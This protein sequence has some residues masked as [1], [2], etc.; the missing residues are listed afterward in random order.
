M[1]SED[2]EYEYE[3]DVELDEE[4]LE[5]EDEVVPSR[6][7]RKRLQTARIN[8]AA[9]TMLSGALELLTPAAP[10]ADPQPAGPRTR[11]STEALLLF[12]TDPN[13]PPPDVRPCNTP[14][15]SKSLQD[16]TSEKIYHLFGNRYFRNYEH[17]GQAS[18]DAKL[19]QGG[20]PCPTIGEFAKIRKCN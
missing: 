3:D 8:P 6:P 15:G 19:V 17:Y 9:L 7:P 20:E 10:P 16:L 18:K 14:N 1:I 12:S 5:V 11:I 2:A 4:A 13:A